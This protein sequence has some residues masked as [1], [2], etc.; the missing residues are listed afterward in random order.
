MRYSIDQTEDCDSG[1][2]PIPTSLT[3]TSSRCIRS[4]EERCQAF[5][6][7]LAAAAC[8]RP[9][10]HLY[11]V[12]SL[13]PNAASTS[14]VHRSIT[15]VDKHPV[16]ST[17]TDTHSHNH[18]ITTKANRTRHLSRPTSHRHIRA[19]RNDPRLPGPNRRPPRPQSQPPIQRSHQQLLGSTEEVPALL[20]R[21][22]RESSTLP[23]LHRLVLQ[24][25]APSEIWSA[26]AVDAGV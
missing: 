19:P 11:P 23:N 14:Q 6:V 12:P 5:H 1:R 26:G 8:S 7:A 22:S 4:R 2:R 13:L 17:V 9:I 21:Q 10:D 24:L 18:G 25:S 15:G 3:V 16:R 20:I